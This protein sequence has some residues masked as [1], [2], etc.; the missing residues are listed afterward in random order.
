MLIALVS[1]DKESRHD[2]PGR[3]ID[4]SVVAPGAL[5]TKAEVTQD[6]LKDHLDSIYIYG[7]KSDGIASTPVVSA[8]GAPLVYNE[9]HGV[10]NPKIYTTVGGSLLKQDLQWEEKYYYRFYGFAYSSNAKVAS[11]PSPGKDLIIIN[12]TY[13]RQFTVTQPA[14]GDG[15]STIDYLLSSLVAV[16]PSD[17]YPVVPV[18]LEHAM[19]RIDVDVQIAKSM[20]DA[21]ECLVDNI[22]VKIDS[23]KREATMLCLEPKLY[24]DEGT[25]TW[26]ITFNDQ[27]TLAT[28]SVDI[29]APEKNL[30]D[31]D[32]NVS[33]NMSF[34]AVPVTSSEMEDYVL[35]LE[36]KGKSSGTIYTYS[37][38]L[39][40]FSPSGWLNG[41]KVKYVLTIDNSIHLKGTIV[42]YEDVDYIEGVIIPDINKND[43]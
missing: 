29:T 27:Q 8:P 7:I 31:S 41:H 10:W 36:Y 3:S 12:N 37:F 15:S 40:N 11:S 43:E 6:R 5:K 33:P 13:G 38:D 32:N 30:E 28:Y 35:T 2:A 25:N 18:L 19:A 23:I 1:C 22:K 20:F 17:N 4:F 14:D 9:T 42:D 21:G 34:I 16:S 26:Y 24:G 39:K